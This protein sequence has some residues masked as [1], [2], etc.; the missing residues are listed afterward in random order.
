MRMETVLNPGFKNRAMKKI[1]LFISIFPFIWTACM[2]DKGTYD[3][4]D[5]NEIT[6][7]TIQT[8]IVEVYDTLKVEPTVTTSQKTGK[9]EYCWYRYTNEDLNVDTLSLEEKLVYKVTLRVGEYPIY[10][11][12]TDVISGLSGKISFKL[13]VVGKF[14]AGL[15]VLGEENGSPDLIFINSAGNLTTLYDAANSGVLGNKPVCIADASSMQ[16]SSVK[17]MLVLTDDGQGGTTLRSEDFSQGSNLKELFFVAPEVFKPQAYYKSVDMLEYGTMADFIINDGKLH[18]RFQAAAQEM[19]QKV[20]FNPAVSGNYSLSPWA[21]VNGKSWLFYDNANKRFLSL[22]GSMMSIDKTFSAV[23]S[24][25][26]GFDPAEMGMKLVYMAEGQKRGNDYRGFGIFRDQ[27][28]TLVRLSFSLGNFRKE[29]MPVMSLLANDPVTQDAVEI[30]EA[31]GYAMSLAKPYLYYSKGSKIYQY[32]LES[33][34]CFPVYDVDTI[35]GLGNSTIDKI[36]IEYSP[37]YFGYGNS[38][39]E[40]N[41]VLY[42]SSSENGGAG[43]NGS[44][45]VLKLSENGTVS[46][47]T[48]LYRNVC[49]KT[50]SMCY[51]R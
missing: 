51:K 20:G 33:N 31:T 47:R 10:L 36:Y 6:I 27:Q 18:V 35:P 30:D 16:I 17:D 7:D 34:I 24:S 19:G 50:V 9:L 1:L 26:A 46:E 14:S 25:T 41:N 21:I 49:G 8:R 38:S 48:A 32:E 2:E 13:S 40:Y 37:Y 11:K 43:K 5:I 3:Y 45:H 44:I 29:N 4:V 12:V 28:N 23:T 42:V 15:M 22:R 39:E